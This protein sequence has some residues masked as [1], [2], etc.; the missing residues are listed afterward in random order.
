MGAGTASA[1]MLL[2]DYISD[3]DGHIQNLLS[4]A[5]GILGEYNAFLHILNLV[6]IQK[7]ENLGKEK[8]IILNL[9]MWKWVMTIKILY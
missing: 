3:I 1:I 8:L 4:H 2:I 6:S 9:K 7:E 5:H